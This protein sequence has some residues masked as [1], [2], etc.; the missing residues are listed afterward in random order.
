MQQNEPTFY[1]GLKI[2]NFR[3]LNHIGSGGTAEVWEVEDPNLN[4]WAMKIF[5]PTR[6]MDESAIRL[7]K[8]EFKNTE[9]LNHPNILRARKYGEYENKPYMIFDLCDS[10]LMKML[11]D[12]MHASKILNISH[13]SYF[14]EEILAQVIN[15]VGGALEYLHTKGIVHQDIKPDNILVK[16]G[17]RDENTYMISDFGVS[18][19]IKMTILRDSQ[20]YTESNKG[21]TPDYASPELYQGDPIPPTDIFALGISLFELCTG[22]PPVS[23]TSMTTAIALLNNIPV[24][25]DLPDEYTQRFETLVKKCIELHPEDRPTASD[26][27]RWTTFYLSEQYWPDEMNPP[28]PVPKPVITGTFWND[29][30]KYRKPITVSLVLVPVIWILSTFLIPRFFNP[31][32]SMLTAIQQL[33]LEKAALYFDKLDETKKIEWKHLNNMA[34]LQIST[35]YSGANFSYLVVKDKTSGKLGLWDMQGNMVMESEYDQILKIYDP[36]V[37]TVKKNGVCGQF[38]IKTSK[39][40]NSG[41]CKV[42][43][44]FDSYVKDN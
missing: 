16:T 37:V 33:D 2:D 40:N 5:S 13:P 31:E 20:V 30:K 26:L 41:N 14:S 12:R 34:E 44:S 39:L 27:V 42:F 24:K 21:L 9:K 32:K 35:I 22:R 36:K 3:L 11:M 17:F 10:S 1:T 43:K 6:G 25:T 18:T 4:K 38:N 23:N 28:V 7:F 8:L 15:Q 19:D 29:V